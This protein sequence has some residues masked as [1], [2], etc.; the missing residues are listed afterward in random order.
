MKL[1]SLAQSFWHSSGLFILAIACGLVL[2][3]PFWRYWMGWLSFFVLIPFFYYLILL[4]KR[5]LKPKS[6]VAYIWVTGWVM[7][8]GVTFWIIQTE[9]ARWTGLMGW[10]SILLLLLTYM[11]FSGILAIG[12]ILFG[13]GWTYVKVSFWQKRVFLILPAVWVVC[14]W[15]RGW[16]FSIISTG[17]DSLV[18]PHWN[19]GNLGFAAGVTPLV[20]LARLGGLLGV[21]FAVVVVNLCFFWLL[22]K[23]WKLPVLI[24]TI[25]SAVTLISWY[26][27]KSP[28]GPNISVMALQ[29][30]INENREIGSIDYHD[31]L[32]AIKPKDKNDIIVLPEYSSVFEN[33]KK[34]SDVLTF[35]NLTKNS[36]T[37]I[38]TSRQTEQNGKSFNTLTVYKNDSSI[39][40]EHNK[41]FLIPVG[42]AM[43]YAFLL[44][45]RALKQEEVVKIREI[46]KGNS[47]STV[48]AANGISIGSQA[49]SGAI[50]PEMYRHLVAEGA[51]ILTNSASLSIFAGAQS[52]HNQAQ[53]MARFM[54]VANAR[55]FVQATDGSYSFIVDSNGQWLAKSSQDQLEDINAMVKLNNT[56][57]LYSIYGEWVYYLSIGVL[58]VQIYTVRKSS[59][60]LK[61]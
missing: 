55:P 41:N 36:I 31:Y 5:Q 44:P 3:L 25:I 26:L 59:K 24:L 46:S 6:Q 4:K 51:Q 22:H 40:Y 27:Y 18:G 50:T 9:P 2:S 19:F 53:Q 8:L 16:I 10:L 43:P 56:K 21:S 38:I 60:K 58:I 13:I 30:G 48:F 54:A 1:R 33:D 57:T 28:T 14:E 52:Y 42:E 20:F 39:T 37:P 45:L 35:A 47:S 7:M 61:K 11:L 23:R 29:F 15:L 34:Q 49:C 12:F 32:A 17:P